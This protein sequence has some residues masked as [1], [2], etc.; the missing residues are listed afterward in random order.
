MGRL[1]VKPPKNVLFKQRL[2]ETPELPKCSLSVIFA[3]NTS[4][5]KR[6]AL[7]AR[8]GSEQKHSWHTD[9]TAFP[10]IYRQTRD[11]TVEACVCANQEHSCLSN[12][13][14]NRLWQLL[15]W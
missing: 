6:K 7:T 10:N 11:P 4:A 3:E 12:E 2:D 13:I 8:V 1:R 5:V 15:P 14:R 9:S